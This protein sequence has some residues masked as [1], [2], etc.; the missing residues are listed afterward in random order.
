MKLLFATGTRFPGGSNDTNHFSFFFF[1]IGS[2]SQLSS[3]LRLQQIE[4]KK[5]NNAVD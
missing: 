5:Q 4:K 3:Q 2:S 1:E